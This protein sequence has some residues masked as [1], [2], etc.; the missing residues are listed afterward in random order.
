MLPTANLDLFAGIPVADT[1][2]QPVFKK[3]THYCLE[4]ITSQNRFTA[5]QL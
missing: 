1:L 4:Q 2:G 5:M 3:M